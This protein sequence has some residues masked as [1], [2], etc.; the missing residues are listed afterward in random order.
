[1]EYRSNKDHTSVVSN[2]ESHLYSHERDKSLKLLNEFEELFNVTLCYGRTE[3]VS[4]TLK[5]SVKP[6]HGSPYP[7]QTLK[8]ET[9]IKELNTLCKLR[10]LE[11]KP[12]SECVS[13]S[14]ILP[15]ADQ[16][17]DH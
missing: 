9:I 4:F 10:A 11:F 8:K 16:T 17:N 5:K 7:V 2:T 12:A 1:M 15:Q 3:P 14:F 13:P 6:Y